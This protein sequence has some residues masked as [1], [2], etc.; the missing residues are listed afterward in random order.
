VGAK[1]DFFELGGTSL[2]ATSVAIR[3]SEKGY[4]L[5]YGDV[6]RYTTPRSLAE[7]LGK[8]SKPS[9]FEIDAAEF[10]R[11]DYSKIDEILSRNNLDSYRS[12]KRREI[13]NI[14]LTGATG[15]MGV[16]LL[17]AF[18]RQEKG[19][20]YCIVRK[21][22]GMEAAKRLRNSMFYYF[23]NDILEL[24]DK[25]VTVVDGDVT[26]YETFRTLENESIDTV[27]NC[28]AN[29]KHF[30]SGTDIEDINVGGVVNCIRF[31]EKR[32][33]RLIHFSTISVGGGQIVSNP[34]EMRILDEQTLYFG[35]QLN[36]QYISSKMLAERMLLEA[37]ADSRVDGKII[38]VGTLAPRD[39]DGEFQIN[40]RS[41]S[42]IGRLRAYWMLKAFPYSGM[43]SVVRMGPIDTSVDAFLRLART[44]KDCTLFNAINS[45]STPIINIIRGMKKIGME[46]RLVEN[47]EFKAIL[48]E[49]EQDPEKVK[50][51]QS[52]L[53]YQNVRIAK[54]ARLVEASCEYT[55]QVLAREGF[56]WNMTDGDYIERFI[57]SLET[58]DF[59]DEDSLVR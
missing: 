11:Y 23:E 42:F 43:E 39:S 38:R 10:D 37:I 54:A 7:F 8:S 25:R 6:F 4:Q 35:Q 50:I 44:P 16:H 34:S 41:N 48:Q 20:A 52:L 47:D 45:N 33:A 32:N 58:L 51:L 15:F 27:F 53:A 57:K 18:L 1:D 12:G 9:G 26:N 14:L 36:N 59:F 56:F 29:V 31:C 40:Y 55:T 46:I 3:A 30:S 2:I 22:H 13:G 49:A 21:G 19:R 17:A 24:V 5:N 28:A